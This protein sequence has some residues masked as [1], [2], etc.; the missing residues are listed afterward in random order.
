MI[1]FGGRQRIHR[2]PL[3]LDVHRYWVSGLQS[4]CLEIESPTAPQLIAAS[5]RPAHAG[6]LLG[7]AGREIVGR[8][9]PLDLVISRPGRSARQPPGGEPLSN[10]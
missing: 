4:E 10:R 8:V 6:P 9:V 2:R 5:L 1:N 3:T 7:I